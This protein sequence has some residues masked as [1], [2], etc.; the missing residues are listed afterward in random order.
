M[1]QA[2]LETG[3]LDRQ[4]EDARLAAL[5]ATGILDTP[6]EPCYDA[7]SRLAAE[8]FRADSA[9]IGFADDSRV[10]IKSH[11]GNHVLELPRENSI[12]E[13]VLAEDGPVTVSELSERSLIEESSQILR[14]HDATFFASA[15]VRSSDGKILGVL[16][17]F[18]HEDSA[19]G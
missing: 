11:W 5:N 18:N 17:I 2:A 8:Y 10:W 6:P 13:M 1:P 12:F 7:I 14:L 19:I 3:K 15:P 16:S 4:Q 9:G